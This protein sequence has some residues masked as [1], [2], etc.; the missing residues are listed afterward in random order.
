MNKFENILEDLE[1]KITNLN[2]KDITN[3]LIKSWFISLNQKDIKVLTIVGSLL[4]QRIT[5]LFMD[6]KSSLLTNYQDLK[7]IILLFLPYINDEN[8]NVYK[9]I[10]DLNELI[11]TDKITP[12]TLKLDRSEV[13]KSHFKFTNM[14]IGLFDVNQNLD[15]DDDEFEKIIYKIIYHNLIS[16]IDTIAIV[17]GKL[18]VNWINIIPLNLNNYVNSRIYKNTPKELDN[19][20]EK[21]KYNG[22]YIGEFYNVYR[23]IFY[24]DIKKVK[25]LIFINNGEE[26]IIQYL[27]KIFN[28]NIFFESYSYDDLNDKEKYKFDNKL[29]AITDY[30]IWKNII[31]WFVNNYTKIKLILNK[32][33]LKPFEMEIIKEGKDSE[34]IRVSRNKFDN[35]SNEQIKNFIDNIESSHVWSFIKESLSIFE[36]TIYAKYLIKDNK[37][38]NKLYL[39]ETKINLKNIYNIAKT[40]SHDNLKDWNLLPIKYSSLF[41]DERVYFWKKFNNRIQH[42]DWLQLRNNL[43]LEGFDNYDDRINEIL[44]NFNEIKN[45]LVWEYLV[46]NGLLS[47]FK[48]YLESDES[49]KKYIKTELDK[50]DYK[51]SYY[52]LTNKKYSEH[53]FRVGSEDTSYL[54]NVKTKKWY[55][56]YAMNWICQ[57]NFYQHYLNHRVLYITGATG[58]GKSTQVPKLLMYALKMLDYKNNGKV[59]C[60]QP[61]IGPTNSNAIR[62]SEEL[63]V[64]IQEYSISLKEKIKS[65]KYYV[66]FKH[67]DEKHINELVNHLSLSFV[68]DGTLLTEIRKNPMLKEEIISKEESIYTTKNKYDI[69][70]IDEAHEHNTNMDL[71]LTLARQSCYMNNDL[72]LIIMSATMDDDEP[73]FRRYYSII[74]DNLVYP[75]KSLSKYELPYDSIYELPYD[76]IYLDRRFHIAPPGKS[77]QHDIKEIYLENGNTEDIINNIIQTTTFGDIL[78]FENGTSD[79]MKRVKNLNKITPGN[80][81]AIPYLGT[82]LNKKYKDIIED[83]INMISKIRTAKHLVDT[84]WN[85]NYKISTDVPEGTYNRAIIVATNVAEA[86]LT[87]ENLK[88]VIDNGFAKVNQYNDA[89]DEQQLIEESISEASRKQ[90]KGRVG[91]VASGTVYYLYKKGEKE[92]IK[93]KYKINQENFGENLL[94]LLQIRKLNEENI[95]LVLTDYD[96]NIPDYF[97]IEPTEDTFENLM[98]TAFYKKEIYNIQY[99]Q[100]YVDNYKTYWDEKYF[101]HNKIYEFMIRYESGY[102]IHT[103]CDFEGEFYIIH[104]KENLIKRNI[105]GNII[106]Y[107]DNKDKFIMDNLLKDNVLRNL[108]INQSWRYFLVDMSTR[109]YNQTNNFIIDDKMLYK[110][111]FFEYVEKLRQ[112]IDSYDFETSDYVTLLTSQAY[113]SFNEVLEVITMLKVIKNSMKNLII[114]M[115]IFTS[116]DNEIEFIFNIIDEFKKKFYYFKIFDIKNNLR[117]KYKDLV[118]KKIDEYLID[119]KY[120][121][122]P[123]PNKYTAKEWNNLNQLYLTGRLKNGFDSLVDDLLEK[124]SMINNFENYIEEIKNWANFNNLK[125]TAL[126]DYL[127]SYKKYNLNFLTRKKNASNNLEADPLS[128]MDN[129]SSSFK[130]SLSCRNKYEKIIRPF[131][132]GKPYN[133]AIRMKSSDNFYTTIPPIHLTNN[134]SKANINNILFYFNKKDNDMS[135]T[136]KIEIDWLFNVLPIYYKP[137]NFKNIILKRDGDDINQLFLDGDIFNDFCVNLRNKYSSNNLPFES[138]K[139]EIL[140]EFIKNIKINL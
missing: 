89:T 68:T 133:F 59:V 64:P 18:Y 65:D 13:L 137:S 76:S 69:M 75:I 37:I 19:T 20:I 12:A 14:G 17:N 61:R 106:G 41:P 114:D 118:D 97:I 90:R 127:Y 100:F 23:N 107:Y 28:F 83:L 22:L 120:K 93:S 26:Y 91:R 85:E 21:Y 11:L 43:K 70:I 66:Q 112:L 123:P 99:Q 62:V 42:Q 117:L 77:T 3:Q 139:K 138:S 132:H 6:D 40:L 7:A 55:T 129:E 74:N 30:S 39:P 125:E 88:F 38:I 44:S 108:I 109:M 84:T 47:D 31:V 60:T 35:I 9:N 57:I 101:K 8:P 126:I 58:Q 113:E 53:N 25:W 111:E 50:Q 121:K 54:K 92:S 32:E 63:G 56:F 131:I 140:R 82:G 51:D 128:E 1:G 119:R 79:I 33:I 34:L 110:T 5:E 2:I 134:D 78:V 73:N 95:P 4:V 49:F 103:L 94:S 80:V 104:P 71:I 86:S 115:K 36:S 124:D 135:I 87:I 10:K 16:L 72:K 105:L 45:K 52:Y 98:T 130:K 46:Y 136:N 67:S 81:I 15:L 102:N 27:D 48:V 122:D 96:P 24:E 116:Q 29:K